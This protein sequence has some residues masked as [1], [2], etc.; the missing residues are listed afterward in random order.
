MT[1]HV[2]PATDSACGNDECCDVDARVA[3]GPG[4]ELR[5]GR[6]QDVLADVEAADAVITDPPY[7]ERTHAGHQKGF[8]HT[9]NGRPTTRRDINYQSIGPDD[10][11][12]FVRS[13]SERCGGWFCVFSDDVLAP[14]WR[15]A[16]DAAGRCSFAPLAVVSIGSTVRLAGDGP[17]SWT[18]WLN[19]A[20]PR[21]SGFRAWGTLPGAYISNRITEQ[22]RAMGQKHIDTMRAIVRDY[23]RPGDLIVDP[24]AGGATTLL[25]AVLEGRRAIGAEVDPATFALAVKRLEGY[26]GVFIDQPHGI[27]R[28]PRARQ[29]TLGFDDGAGD[30]GA[31]NG[32][33]GA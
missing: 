3:R 12:T 27:A 14:D 24:C 19:V 2:K 30:G 18:V 33:E 23:S 25:A 1:L 6:W 17:S 11:Q 28:A 22:T 5:L 16:L 15:A 32:G 21:S 4:W 8:G 20:R 10:V 7:S 9:G 26:R 29:Q 31:G 13:W